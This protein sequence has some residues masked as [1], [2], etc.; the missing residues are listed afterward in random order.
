MYKADAPSG[1]MEIELCG[2]R[3]GVPALTRGAAVVTYDGTNVCAYGSG[4]EKGLG[5]VFPSPGG[6][7]NDGMDGSAG[8]VVIA[9]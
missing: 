5:G 1:C 7:G 8:N 4:G 6:N 3:F 2:G 9:N